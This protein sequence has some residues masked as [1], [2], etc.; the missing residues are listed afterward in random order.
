MDLSPILAKLEAVRARARQLVTLDG[1]CRVVLVLL[2]AAI[3]SFCIDYFIPKLPLG[4]R[5]TVLIVGLAAAGVAAWRYLMVPLS[6]KFTDDDLAL[7]VEQQ[8]PDLQDR[9]I[10]AIQL[11]RERGQFSNFN[12]PQLVDALV[13]DAMN[14][15]GPLDFSPVIVPAGPLKVAAGTGAALLV[16]LSLAA[17]QFDSVKTW[18][19]RLLSDSRQWPQQTQIVMLSPTGNPVTVAK[20]DDLEIEILTKGVVPRKA[21]I[22]YRFSGAGEPMQRPMRAETNGRWR[23]EFSKVIEPIEFWVEAGDAETPHIA[24]QVLNPPS[25]ERITLVYDYPDYTLLKDTDPTTPIEDGN[26]VGPLGTHVKVTALAN[27]DVAQAKMMFGRRG[28]E[29]VRDLVVKNDAQGRP[30]MIV[31]DVD[32]I[33]NTQY[34]IWLK[35]T[36]GLQTNSPVRYSIK[37]TE[38]KSPEL[39]ISEPNLDKFCTAQARIPI[40]FQSTDD[41]GVVKL[42]L[43]V[44]TN[45]PKHPEVTIPLDA[46][47]SESYPSKRIETEYPFDMAEFGAKEGMVIQYQIVARDGREIP[48]AN[49]TRSRVF[50]FTVIKRDD[51]L[52]KMEDRFGR[53]REELMRVV[54]FQEGGRGEVA[55][56]MDA[57]GVKDMLTAIERQAVNGA[58]GNQR[59]I[60]QHMERITHDFDEVVRDMRYNKLLEGSSEARLKKPADLLHGVTETKSPDT[61]SLLATA[62]TV[63]QAKERM[64][65][66][67]DTSVKQEDI[68]T[69]L[70]T[71][72]GLLNEY[73]TYLEVVRYVR[74]LLQK[75]KVNTEEMRH[76]G[77]PK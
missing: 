57:V 42:E 34:A 50:L 66:L 4:V 33:T 46:F 44:R 45:D 24:V 37:A 17:W 73:E 51:L 26:I 27:L 74:E 64:S 13:K 23:F 16:A 9:L 11:A 8:Y 62:G 54:Q 36:N 41:F 61:A 29:D 75:V 71:I 7:Y 55:R 18:A 52:K 59:R 1:A 12:S 21:V 40:K 69:D 32:V 58:A 68:L 38:D 67:Q 63:G 19:A 39:K 15:A 28:E 14:E 76:T 25:I 5:T 30:R 47:N 43:V 22:S 72:L 70:G 56:L 49:E 35:A 6:V 20:G 2:V 31:A 48:K 77:N 53:I 3:F 10:S 60:T 65:R